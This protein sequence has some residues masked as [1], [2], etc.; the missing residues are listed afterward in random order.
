LGLAI[1]RKIARLH[2]GEVTLNGAEGMGTEATITM[3]KARV[4]WPAALKKSEA[5]VAA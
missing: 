2:G 1:A 5:S 4:R 3:P